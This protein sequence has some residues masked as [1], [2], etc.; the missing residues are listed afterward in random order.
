MPDRIS[1][2]SGKAILDKLENH[3]FW[4]SEKLKGQILRRVGE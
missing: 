2:S 4:L 3:G 1:I